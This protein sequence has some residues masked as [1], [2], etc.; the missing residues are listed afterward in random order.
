MH[1]KTL[2]LLLTFYF[3]SCSLINAQGSW[4]NFTG[5]PDSLWR[6]MWKTDTAEILK[7][8][9]KVKIEH[10]VQKEY[11]NFLITMYKKKYN[12][13]SIFTDVPL[14]NLFLRNPFVVEFPTLRDYEYH[15]IF[16]IHNM[17]MNE[18]Y[19]KPCYL[20]DIYEIQKFNY[21]IRPA[22]KRLGVI[23]DTLRNLPDPKNI[24]FISK[25]AT[26]VTEADKYFAVYWKK[27][28][29]MLMVG[30]SSFLNGF[31]KP[32][33]SDGAEEEIAKIY[34]RSRMVGRIP[35]DPDD[36]DDRLMQLKVVERELD[37]IGSF[38]N[39]VL[40]FVPNR[41]STS[42]SSNKGKYELLAR[43]FVLFELTRIE[44]K[45]SWSN[46]E[47]KLVIVSFPTH[48]AYHC[49]ISHDTSTTS[50]VILEEPWNH[51][52]VITIYFTTDLMERYKYT[53]FGYQP[54][55]F[56]YEVK[57]IFKSNPEMAADNFPRVRGMN[58]EEFERMK[59]KPYIKV[60]CHEG[61]L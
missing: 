12:I 60:A 59:A 49:D 61:K 44:H 3:T 6:W 20:K 28:T 36:R 9:E 15:P 21:F 54:G 45:R 37:T 42:S 50:P 35:V 41:C 40:F 27:G 2:L 43:T 7:V 46:P 24:Y 10:F 32:A 51:L 57:Q 13:D 5:E 58:R 25:D 47:P 14:M 52:N 30:G 19:Y 31:P 55:F 23:A 38:T 33:W 17:K 26:E 11:V 4:W 16:Q 34:V 56:A 53:N 29:A 22:N 1:M 8:E 39:G 48:A 18:C